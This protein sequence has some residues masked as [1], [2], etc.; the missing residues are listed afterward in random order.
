MVAEDRA[1][2]GIFRE[3]S[4]LANASAANLNRFSRRGLVSSRRERESLAEQSNVLRIR[5]ASDSIPIESL[6]GGNQQKV[7]LARWLMTHPKILLLDEPTRGIDVG[8]KAEIYR[9]IRELASHGIGV[10]FVSSEQPEV[11]GLADRI[12]VMSNG[13]IAA[14]LSAVDATEE[15]ILQAAMANL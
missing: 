14:E 2:L 15:R 5:R 8:A 9:T 3:Q 4:V 11:L 13:S 12:L 6:S 1:A 10:I 7:I